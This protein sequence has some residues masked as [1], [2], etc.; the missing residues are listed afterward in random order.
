MFE[1]KPL[2]KEGIAAALEK[3]EQY[4]LLNEPMLAESICLDVLEVDP[5]NQRALVSL[6]LARTDQFAAGGRTLDDARSLLPG[7]S[8]E[9]DRVYYAGIICERWAKATLSRDTPGCGPIAYEWFRQAME[10]YEK[11]EPLRP[12]GHDDA[13]LRW[14]TCA[15]MI[16]RHEH[17]RPRHE[18]DF[19]PMLE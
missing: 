9:Y 12:P 18:D 7:L 14:N 15:R 8:A 5:G 13:I 2:S 1:L 19:L 16:A 3:V 4:R 11:A 6:L 17:V 10:W